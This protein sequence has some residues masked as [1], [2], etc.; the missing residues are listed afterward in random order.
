M[1]DRKAELERKKA[2]LEQ[3]R[4][5]RKRKQEESQLD[6]SGSVGNVAP[7]VKDLRSE[8]EELLK[9][10]GIPLSSDTG[11]AQQRPAAAAAE[12]KSADSSANLQESV[13]AAK[14]PVALAFSKVTQTNLVPKDVVQYNKETQTPKET[15]EREDEDTE[16]LE[17]GVDTPPPIPGG[18]GSQR[19]GMPHT[20]MHKPAETPEDLVAPAIDEK[21]VVIELSE[22]ERRKIVMS[23]DFLNFFSRASAVVERAMFEEVDIFA[24][25]FG[26][27]DDDQRGGQL[28]GEQL[29][30][31]RQ[32]FDERWSKHRTVTSLDWSTQFPELLLSSYSG[33]K[34]SPNEPE[35]VALVWNIKFKKTTPEFIFHCQSPV[36]SACF[37]NFHPN[38]IV[39]GTYSGQI[40][41]WD[42]RSHKHTPVQRTPLS[43]LAVTHTHPVYCI[44]VV[45]SQN[46]HNL[47]SLSTDGKICFW[48]LDMLSQPQD[49]LELQ[50][51]QNRPV[52][53][54]CCSFPYGDFNNYVVGCE[55]GAVY[56]AC[57]HGSKSG[58]NEIFESHQGPVTG[59]DCHAVPGAVD[60]SPYFLTSSFDWTVKL[61]NMKEN[62][63]LHSFEDNSDYIFDVKW[64]PIHPALF[65]TVD[66][67]GRLDLWNLNIETEVP[68]AS[69]VVENNSGLNKCRWHQAGHTIAAGD[70]S[71]KIHVYEV[72]EPLAVPRSDDWSKFSHTLQELKLEQVEQE[73]ENSSMLSQSPMR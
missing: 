54:W 50:Y 1:A 51:K 17:V 67:S 24:D 71:G 33:N 42:N 25:Y 53:S 31:N 38:L 26:T 64:S 73:E 34:D 66:G 56:T 32:F 5:E 47:V 68:T 36:T 23:E 65:S 6:V 40:V 15:V 27:D 14:K 70:D 46:A 13:Y 44:D 62:R 19:G 58:I 18:G 4:A 2:K 60:F 49:S 7:P 29:K 61:W 39:G 20:T 30:L 10:I 45:G 37:A 21:P 8:T 72:G 59:V 43:A 28:E 69:V 52:A 3:M 41:L 63:L 16:S 11:H 22:E 55:D 9:D 57:R 35:G 48:S 12:S